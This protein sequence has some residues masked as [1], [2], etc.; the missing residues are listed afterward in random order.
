MAHLQAIEVGRYSIERLYAHLTEK[1]RRTL[2]ERC[3]EF[4]DRGPVIWHVNSTAAG[5]GVA[6]MIAPLVGYGRELGLDVRWLVIQAA[7]EFFEVTKRVDN[8]ISGIQG[9]GGSLG[10]AEH[11]TY[12][13]T[14]REAAA[15]LRAHVRSGDFVFLHDPQTAGLVAEISRIGAVPIWRAHNGADHPNEHTER[16]WA[17]LRRYLIEARAFAFTM[18]HFSPA[19]MTSRP[20]YTI[21]PF[22]DPGSPKTP[23]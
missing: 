17:F 4:A 3:R 11:K 23:G 5:G 18:P 13:G 20:V 21:T 6:E 2:I 14:S 9:G 15:D 10:E 12:S 19:W 16:A 22:I 7:P 8:G 1:D